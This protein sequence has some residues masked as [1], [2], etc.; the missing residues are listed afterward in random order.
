MAKRLRLRR[1]TTAQTNAFTGELSEVTVD[2]DKKVLVVH[3]GTTAGGFPVAAR[4]NNDGTIS[5]IKKDGTIITT[6]SASGLFNNTLTS[7]A[8]DQALTAAQGKVLQDSK[9]NKTENAVS[10]TKLATARTIALSG[11]VTG[12]ATSFDGSG[13]I[14]IPVTAIDGSKITTGTIPADRIPTLNQST[15]GNAATATKLATARTIDGV[16]FDGTA[17]INLPTVKRTYSLASNYDLNNATDGIH[18]EHSWQNAPSN[19]IGTVA[20]YKYSNHWIHQLF[21]DTYQGRIH[22]RNRHSGTT[23]D[24]W[25][26]LAYTSD[27]VA[28]ATKLQTARTIGGVSF[29]GT[30]NINLPGVN[31]TGNQDTTGNAATATTATNLTTA[32]GNAPSYA[33]RAWVNFNGTGAVKI[34]GSGNVSSITDNGTGDYTV[35]FSTAMPNTNY[36]T[37]FGVGDDLGGASLPKI[38]TVGNST[39]APK[40]KTVNACRIG[41]GGDVY[42]FSAVFFA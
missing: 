19:N 11:G 27:N 6:I 32:S 20:T 29:D 3:D 23:W 5:L 22:A 38:I 15:T 17:D 30:A 28:S 4:A 14:S 35:N 33:A 42:D 13:N 9:L 25:K 36:A 34:N 18:S 37:V 7:T 24:N 21:F 39:T 8:T 1:G 40:T 16:N 41:F 12:T 26:T 2:T 10:A 31:T